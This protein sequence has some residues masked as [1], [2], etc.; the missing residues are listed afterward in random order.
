MAP[1]TLTRDAL[2]PFPSPRRRRLNEHA[3]RLVLLTAVSWRVHPWWQKTL[4]SQRGRERG[5]AAQHG[6]HTRA[7]AGNVNNSRC[8]KEA[9]VERGLHAGGSAAAPLQA[10]VA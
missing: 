4:A 5:A 3:R 6:T 1:R 10:A 8:S 9:H 7:V 2:S